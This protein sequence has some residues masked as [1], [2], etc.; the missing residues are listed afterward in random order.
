MPPTKA[1]INDTTLVM[2]RMQAVQKT[3]DIVTQSALK[4][5]CLS[6]SSQ[7][8]LWP[9]T[10]Y[11]IGLLAVED[12]EGK[13]NQKMARPTSSAAVGCPLQQERESETATEV[14]LGRVQALQNKNRV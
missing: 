7:T 14:N 3:M 9:L 10:I 2:N 6:S 8:L 5:G 13:V 4:C 12:L 1:F 11:D